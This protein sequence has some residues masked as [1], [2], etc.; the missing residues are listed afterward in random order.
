MKDRIDWQRIILLSRQYLKLNL[1]KIIISGLTFLLLLIAV[2]IVSETFLDNPVIEMV[3]SVG[4]MIYGCLFFISSMID[5]DNSRRESL[6]FLIPAS[7]MEKLISR[8]MLTIPFYFMFAL[9]LMYI[10]NL[11]LML[12]S[13]FYYINMYQINFFSEHFLIYYLIFCLIASMWMYG[14]VYF[15]KLSIL[16]TSAAIVIFFFVFLVVPTLTFNFTFSE[17]LGFRSDHLISPP[18]QEII[19][20]LQDLYLI[21]ILSGIMILITLFFQYLT[22]LRL[23]EREV[24]NGISK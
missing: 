17:I 21:E 23:I 2:S 22:Y 1:K 7:I 18:H 19:L 10:S 24:F 5:F 14:I 9:S 12:L 6:F 8:I 20:T 16:K 4:F 15:K 13:H 3:F 11:I